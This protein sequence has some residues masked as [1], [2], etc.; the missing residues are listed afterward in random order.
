MPEQHLA[1][2]D[3]ELE[4]PR[5]LEHLELARTRQPGLD[6]LEDL[7]G[8]GLHHH[9]AVGEEHRL[10]DVVRDVEHGAAEGLVDLGQLEVQPLAGEL[11]ERGERLVHKQDV[12]IRDEH[13]REA[14]ALLHPA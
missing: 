6:D 14:G 3:H 4:G 9:D 11:V 7:A 5:L 10:F 8:V 12:G 2:L 1:D 13:A